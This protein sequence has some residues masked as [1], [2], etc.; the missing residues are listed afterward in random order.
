MV[1]TIG[2]NGKTFM[3]LTLEDH[4]V[5]VD[6]PEGF[7]LDHFS[8]PNAK[9]QILALHIQSTIKYTELEQ[10]LAF[11]GSDG[12]PCMTGHTNV[13]IAALK[14]LLR[15][16]Q[17]V[18]CLLHCVA[19]LLHHVFTALDGSTRSPNSFGGPIGKKVKKPVSIWPIEEFKS[20]SNQHFPILHNKT[21]NDLSTDQYYAHKFARLLFWMKLIL[22]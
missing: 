19:L 21:I 14:R 5:M 17:W 16:L 4:Y 13:L 2:K 7:Y 20:I 15:P 10:K 22:M 3:K 18:I 11:I 6:E 9:G 8:P 1:L 12:T